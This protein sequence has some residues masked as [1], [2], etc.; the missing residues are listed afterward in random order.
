[1]ENVVGGLSGSM[2]HITEFLSDDPHFPRDILSDSYVGPC[3]IYQTSRMV[4]IFESDYQT[5]AKT[6]AEVPQAA[7][8]VCFRSTGRDV[9]GISRKDPERAIQLC[10]NVPDPVDPLV[11]GDHYSV[12][13]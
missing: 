3:Y 10:S 6:R 7:H 4:V 13:Q 5:V 8:Q 11:Q 12:C 2:G 1:M 9:G